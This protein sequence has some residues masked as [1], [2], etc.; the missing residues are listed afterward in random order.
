VEVGKLCGTLT[1]E[2]LFRGIARKLA[3]GVSGMH[4]I[5][6]ESIITPTDR[7]PLRSEALDATSEELMKILI[8]AGAVVFACGMSYGASSA[9]ARS[10]PLLVCPKGTKLFNQNPVGMGY[11]LNNWGTGVQCCRIVDN[12]DPH[13]PKLDCVAKVTFFQTIPPRATRPQ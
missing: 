5:R 2:L 6:W 12:T 4:P 10:L 9:N 8:I 13:H 7:T 3:P 11:P 1:A